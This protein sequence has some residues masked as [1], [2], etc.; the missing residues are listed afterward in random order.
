M[1]P[2]QVVARAVLMSGRDQYFWALV[3][4]RTHLLTRSAQNP[5]AAGN[6]RPGSSGAAP[7]RCDEAGPTRRASEWTPFSCLLPYLSVDLLGPS[8]MD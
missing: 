8:F 3:T 7:G 6:T 2:D 5:M 4:A 1:G